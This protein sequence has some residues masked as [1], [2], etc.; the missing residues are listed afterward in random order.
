MYD[1]FY[2]QHIYKTTRGQGWSLGEHHNLP[3][4]MITEKV[5]FD[6][7]DFNSSQAVSLMPSYISSQSSKI[8]WSTELNVEL[9]FRRFKL[10][11]SSA[12]DVSKR[13]LVTLMRAVLVL[14]CA[15]NPDRN[16]SKISSLFIKKI[17]SRWAIFSKTFD[18]NG[19]LEMSQFFF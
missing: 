14:W 15:W 7:Y 6:K 3:F 17:N 5:L 1:V 18:K 2:W 4:T 9:K 8:E 13:L 12:S 10:K 11:Q 16:L 19:N